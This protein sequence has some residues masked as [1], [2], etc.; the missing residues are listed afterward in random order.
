MRGHGRTDCVTFRSLGKKPEEGSPKTEEGTGT[1][2]RGGTGQGV[3]GMCRDQC[4]RR[5][6]KEFLYSTG[7]LCLVCVMLFC[8]N[9]VKFSSSG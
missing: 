8:G 9:F 5:Y 3:V 6:D 7:H 1:D 2:E 4:N